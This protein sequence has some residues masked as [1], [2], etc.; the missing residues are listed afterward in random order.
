MKT[1]LCAALAS[2]LLVACGSSERLTLTTSTE[3]AISADPAIGQVN[4]GYDRTEMVVAPNN[5]DTGAVPS[6]VASLS[7]NGN[8]FDP[9]VHQVFATGTAADI[10][11]GDSATAKPAGNLPAKDKRTVLI[12]GTSTNVGLNASVEGQGLPNVVFGYKRREAATIPLSPDEIGAGT[13]SSVLAAVSV[14]GDAGQVDGTRLTVSQFMATGRAAELLA[15]SDCV[16]ENF[17]AEAGVATAA[18]LR[19]NSVGN[20]VT[21][22]EILAQRVADC[23]RNK[24]TQ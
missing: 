4:I 19:S 12:F 10:V 7:T 11:A 23:V 20:Q 14:D 21:E 18:R 16:K 1:A 15:G 24:Q 2:L 3:I 8:P 17:E 9:K 22:S 13:T 6:V 5:P